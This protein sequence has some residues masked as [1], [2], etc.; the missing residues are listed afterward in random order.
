VNSPTYG[1]RR[2]TTDKF[3]EVSDDSV[4][5][6]QAP[7]RVRDVDGEEEV[8]QQERFGG[9][10]AKILQ[11]LVMPNRTVKSLGNPLIVIVKARSAATMSRRKPPLL[12]E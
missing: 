11:P 12:L 8:G 9:G 2:R 1:W 3:L 5:H 7:Q 10:D 4:F 6:F